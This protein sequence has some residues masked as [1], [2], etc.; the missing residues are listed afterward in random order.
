MSKLFVSI[1]GILALLSSF[2]VSGAN[3][4]LSKDV[5]IIGSLFSGLREQSNLE[6]GEH[7]VRLGKN[8]ENTKGKQQIIDW[9]RLQRGLK[10][11]ENAETCCTGM[12]GRS[13]RNRKG[14]SLRKSPVN[15]VEL[16]Q[17]MSKVRGSAVSGQSLQNNHHGSSRKDEIAKPCCGMWGR[18]L[19]PIKNGS[20]RKSSINGF[21]SSKNVIETASSG[22]FTT[23]LGPENDDKVAEKKPVRMLRK[24]LQPNDPSQYRKFSSKKLY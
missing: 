22:G 24:S 3:D 2:V 10:N 4:K 13:F 21:K 1:V 9:S 16:P 11:T 23:I 7:K 5:E 20:V 8:L 14:R 17:R 18:S 6:S 15:I 12:W 19:R